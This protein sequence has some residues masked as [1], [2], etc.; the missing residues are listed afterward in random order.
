M[1]KNNVRLT[2]DLSNELNQTLDQMAKDSNASKSDILRKSI[3]L[4]EVAL[5]EKKK[6]HHIGIFDDNNKMVKEIV[7]I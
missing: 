7:G 2:L 4:F 3:A 6:K 1:S 5:K